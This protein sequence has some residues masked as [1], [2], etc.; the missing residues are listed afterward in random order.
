MPDGSV[1]RSDV[2]NT[3][4][5]VDDAIAR[6]EAMPEPFFLWVAFNAPHTPLHAP[7]AELVGREV[8]PKSE[9]Y[10]LLVTRWS[11]FRALG[12]NDQADDAAVASD[13]A[14]LREPSGSR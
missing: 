10:E 9:P 4:D 12:Q 11:L 13:H 7:P 14:P 5:T 3:T 8:D 6:V 2:Y 1:V